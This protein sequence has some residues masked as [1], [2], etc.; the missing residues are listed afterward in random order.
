MSDAHVENEAA[1]QAENPAYVRPK[2]IDNRSTRAQRILWAIETFAWDWVYWKPFKAMSVEQAS[3]VGASILRTLGPRTSKQKVVVRNLKLAFPEWDDDQIQ[4]VAR[5]TWD[6]LG[7]IVG[8]MPHLGA[9]RPELGRIDVVH[10]EKLLPLK[11]KGV[12]SVFISGH[13]SN[14]ELFSAVLNHHVPD[15]QLTHRAANNPG[16]D[17]RIN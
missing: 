12:G 3:A 7:R 2:D 8:E 4:I 11:H 9:F 15:L 14:W 5:E 17:Q 6:N 16:V 13:L 1:A 10:P